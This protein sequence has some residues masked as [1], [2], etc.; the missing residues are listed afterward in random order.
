MGRVVQQI[1]KDHPDTID[2]PIVDHYMHS[3]WIL[4]NA[5]N[6][7]LIKYFSGLCV[8]SWLDDTVRRSST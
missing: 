2:I 7:V 4:E 5:V 1:A 6:Y 3:K 8:W